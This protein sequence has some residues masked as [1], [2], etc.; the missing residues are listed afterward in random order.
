MSTTTDVFQSPC[1]T[2]AIRTN[3]AVSGLLT[4]C[5]AVIPAISELETLYGSSPDFK[6]MS[7]QF[8]FQ[9]EANA[10]QAKQSNLYNFIEASSVNLS[11][12]LGKL[13]QPD[14]AVEIMPFVQ[15]KRKG[16]VNNS[17]WAASGGFLSTVDGTADAAGTYWTMLMSSPTGIPLHKDWFIPQEWVFVE[18]LSD[19][20]VMIKWAG[21]IV[22]STVNGTTNIIV[23]MKPQMDNSN[24]PT[25]RKANP[26]QGLATR[27]AGNINK[28]KSFCAQPPSLLTGQ[29]DKY[30]LGWQR[31]TFKTDSS[32]EKWLKLVLND[33]QLFREFY[34]LPTTE[35]NKQVS[36]DFMAKSVES[37][38]NNT[39][40]AGQNDS[41]WQKAPAAGGLP[42]ITTSADSIGGVRCVG[43][44]ANPVGVF[45]QHVQ[46]QRAVDAQGAKL[47]LPALFQSIYK[48]KRI[49]KAA[50]APTGSQN[51]FEIGMPS[52]YFPIFHQGMLEV[53]DA[54]WKGKV[55]WNL[56]ISE[57]KKA[58]MGFLYYEYPLV[59]PVGTMIRVVLDDYFDDYASAWAER[60]T[61]LGDPRLVNLGRRLWILDWSNIWK[62]IADSKTVQ[63]NPG[64][65]LAT[66]QKLGLI[67]PCVME[68]VSESY[69]LRTWQWTAVVQ[70]AAGN[71]IIQNLSD[72]VPEHSIITTNYDVNT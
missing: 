9:W 46:C 4:A 51:V 35:Y 3:I 14:G 11:K 71:L 26:V 50:G 64:S 38:M 62:G 34:Y 8:M 18:A 15:V 23:V 1:A 17:F 40:L 22:K 53:Y 32:Y 41:D 5:N 21:E 31:T 56:D 25:A 66:A 45:E 55:K 30:W 69:T 12:S 63:S 67:D 13:P 44:E 48:M 16:P 72:E 37:F 20:G 42:I 43:R 6:L 29:M 70:C 19:A 65:D 54:Q 61:A 47:N 39:A 60:A 59:F 10:C 7:A 57:A 36:E 49:R 27:G 24:L 33:N 68:T 28:F 2:P 52:N 58:P